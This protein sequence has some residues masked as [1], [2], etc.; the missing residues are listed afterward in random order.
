VGNTG[1]GGNPPALTLLGDGRLALAYGS[2]EAPFGVR[3]RLSEDGGKSWNDEA[4]IRADGGTS[5]I[6]YPKDV[7]LGSTSLLVAYYFND[8]SGLER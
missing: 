2:Q 5:D 1:P 6:G 8:G 3:L 4:I 7:L